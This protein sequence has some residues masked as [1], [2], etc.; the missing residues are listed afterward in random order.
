M[1][2]AA[3]IRRPKT[4]HTS[5]SGSQACVAT[6]VAAVHVEVFPTRRC[7]MDLGWRGQ[8][9]LGAG[10]LQRLAD[11]QSVAI[12]LGISGK[13]RGGRGLQHHRHPDEGNHPENRSVSQARKACTRLASAPSASV[14]Q[15]EDNL[16]E[17]TP[18]RPKPL[19]S[20]SSRSS[21]HLM[22]SRWA[23]ATMVSNWHRT[24]SPCIS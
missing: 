11:L 14:A 23:W 3:K 18:Y 22:P 10:Q 1:E 13:F 9:R 8:C 21:T 12:P 20:M 7:G 2:A 5:R 6:W 15:K 19:G 17:K 4:L 16:P 24:S